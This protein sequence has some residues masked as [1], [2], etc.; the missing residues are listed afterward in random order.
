MTRTAHHPSDALLLSHAAGRLPAGL[1]LV[2]AVHVERCARCA[3][4]V[5]L[6]EAAGGALLDETP[7]VEMHADALAHALATLD[8]PPADAPAAALQQ[9]PPPLP[10]G[11]AWPAALAGSQVAPWRWIGPGM[12]YSRVRLPG[13]DGVIVFLLRLAAG[14][15]LPQH[16]HSGRE[17][18][19]VLCGSFHDGRAQFGAGDFDATGAGVHHLPVVQSD[20]ECVC[21]TAVQGRL[22]FDSFYGRVLGQLAGLS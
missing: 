19:Q 5:G 3:A 4:Y 12:R 7:P 14:K 1:A 17:F 16:A 20:G 9:G 6:L 2:V 18:T 8:A 22:Q 13:D 15:Y 10:V 21:L 11:E